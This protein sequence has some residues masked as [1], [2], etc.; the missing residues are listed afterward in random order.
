LAATD[1]FFAAGA[2]LDAVSDLPAGLAAG[3]DA[4]LAGLFALLAGADF[5]ALFAVVALRAA[6]DPPATLVVMR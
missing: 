1:F 6:E 5:G 4:A 3:F 2:G